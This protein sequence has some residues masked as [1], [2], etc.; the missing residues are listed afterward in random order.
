HALLKDVP[1]AIELAANAADAQALRFI[2][3]KFD[4][5]RVFFAPPDVPAERIAVLGRAF[6]DTMKDPSYLDLAKALGL[7]AN[8]IDG[9]GTARLV[10]QI[11]DTPAPIVDRLR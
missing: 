8:P 7:D 2:A 3:L 10:Q 9:D 6:G 4:L 5:A 1:T 11:Q